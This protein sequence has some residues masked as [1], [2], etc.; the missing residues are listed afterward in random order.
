M[1]EIV[2]FGGEQLGV[3]RGGE[4]VVLAGGVTI[5]EFIVEDAAEEAGI[6]EVGAVGEALGEE[7]A[8]G[9]ALA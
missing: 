2:G 4:L 8:G 5:A 1:I 9:L 3:G 7:I 6:G